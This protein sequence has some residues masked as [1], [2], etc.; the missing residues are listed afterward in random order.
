MRLVQRVVGGEMS[1]VRDAVERLV[2]LEI[3]PRR[4]RGPHAR[5]AMGAARSPVVSAAALV[6]R[7]NL[8]LQPTAAS[9]R[10][11]VAAAEAAR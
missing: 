3:A 1:L 10:M 2:T 6:E 7:P 8:G 5:L 11:R 9:E 4:G